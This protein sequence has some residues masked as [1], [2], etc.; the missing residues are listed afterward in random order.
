MVG[1][2][3]NLNCTL[4]AANAL[5]VTV[6]MEVDRTPVTSGDTVIV[7]DK[8][9]TIPSVQRSHSGNYSCTASNTQGSAVIDHK[10][11]VVGVCCWQSMYVSGGKGA[12]EDSTKCRLW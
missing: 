10:L 11:L 12:A 3:F 8:I 1:S 7:T 4:S 6:S 2:P 5:L 9:L